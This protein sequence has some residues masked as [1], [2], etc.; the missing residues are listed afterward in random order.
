MNRGALNFYFCDLV[1]VVVVVSSRLG[2]MN[3]L[4]LFCFD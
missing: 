3:P 2:L 4:Q 1:V